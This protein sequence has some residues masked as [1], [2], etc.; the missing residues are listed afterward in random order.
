VGEEGGG[1]GRERAACDQ[2]DR[3]QEAFPAK[4]IP[5]RCGERGDERGGKHPDDSCDPD[6]DRPAFVV[7]EDSKGDE[8]RPFG[9]NCSAPC[10]LDSPEVLV[11][12]GSAQRCERGNRPIHCCD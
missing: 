5:E 8:M 7:G 11:A 9:S 3:E 12:Q 4:P 10:K 1:R 6:G 2:R